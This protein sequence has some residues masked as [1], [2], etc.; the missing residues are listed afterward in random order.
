MVTADRAYY[1]GMRAANEQDAEVI[2]FPDQFPA[3]RIPLSRLS[4]DRA[5]GSG[6]AGGWSQGG[7]AL[8]VGRR[9]RSRHIEPDIDLTG[10]PGVSRQ[11]AMLTTAPNGTWTITDQGSPNGT[12][13]NGAE[14][15]VGQAVPLRDGDYVNLGAWTR[16]TITRS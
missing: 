13:V 8:S 9:S 16:I 6:A 15:P 12:L 2:H 11:H 1:D 4:A 14:I 10:D 5:S 3:R 7:A